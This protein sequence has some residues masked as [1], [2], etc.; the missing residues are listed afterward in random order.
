MHYL[1]AASRDVES[2][3]GSRLEALNNFGKDGWEVINIASDKD[4]F[5]IY[6]LKRGV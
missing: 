2:F 1:H 4:G 5:I 3:Q 6:T